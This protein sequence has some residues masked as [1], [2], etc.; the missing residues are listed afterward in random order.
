MGSVTEMEC[1]TSV[2]LP[3]FMLLCSEFNR[4]KKKNK[5]VVK[6]SQNPTILNIFLVLFAGKCFR[7]PGFKLQGIQI[8]QNLTRKTVLKANAVSVT[9]TAS[10]L[11]ES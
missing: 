10:F 11:A 6:F 3:L 9:S 7:Q 8:S 5:V 2:S 4:T 1:P